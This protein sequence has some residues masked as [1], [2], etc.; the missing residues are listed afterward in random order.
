MMVYNQQ[1]LLVA[2][3]CNVGICTVGWGIFENGSVEYDSTDRSGVNVT[4]DRLI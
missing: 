3:Q 2:D 4:A 1:N